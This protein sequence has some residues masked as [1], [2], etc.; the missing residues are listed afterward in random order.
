MTENNITVDD[1]NLESPDFVWIKNRQQADD[2]KLFTTLR[3][4]QKSLEPNEATDEADEPNTLVDF[5][6]NGFTIGDDVTVNTS[7]EDYVAWCWANI[8]ESWSNDASAT[9]IGDYDSSG[10]RSGKTGVSIFTYAGK[11]T[12]ST[13]IRNK[14]AHG[15]VDENGTAVIPELFWFKGID[16]GTTYGG[17]MVQGNAFDDVGSGGGD[18]LKLNTNAARTSNAASA[19]T[20]WTNQWVELDYSR[21]ANLNGTDNICFAF[22]SVEGFSKI[23]T[24]V[25]NESATAGPFT[26]T[27]FKPAWVM[28]KNI[29]TTGSWVIHDNKRT[30]NNS[31]TTASGLSADVTTA[32]STDTTLRADFLS[33][34]FV[35]YSGS[36]SY[37]NSGSTYLY[38]AFA[39]NPFKY[40]NAR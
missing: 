16:T 32:E 26:Y 15:L 31:F 28:V 34:G 10:I 20:Q 33:N 25:G 18:I 1:Q 23:G 37:N 5:N 2:H 35:M 3:G 7:G 4:V 13:S 12:G 29:S 39:E 17:W 6:K 38:M 8:S 27:G 40:S 24:Y 22:R 21:T 30:P 9:G 36:N 19:N 11:G 14:F